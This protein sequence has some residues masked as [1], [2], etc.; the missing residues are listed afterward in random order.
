MDNPEGKTTVDCKKQSTN[1]AL[2]NLNEA[3][4]KLN[5][6]LANTSGHASV[7]ENST[8]A[9]EEWLEETSPKTLSHNVQHTQIPKTMME[10]L[11][12][13]G[14]L[15]FMFTTKLNKVIDEGTI[16]TILTCIF[17]ILSFWNLYQCNHKKRNLSFRESILVWIFFGLSVIQAKINRH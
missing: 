5:E 14:V 12:F 7:E 8:A 4:A 16:L 13:V 15:C 9:L 11:F 6:A 10:F 17:G 2:K 3:L 1:E